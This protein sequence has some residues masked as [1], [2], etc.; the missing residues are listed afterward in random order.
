MNGKITR[1]LKDKRCGFIKGEDRKDY[2]FHQ[3]GLKNCQFLDLEEG[4]KV[5]FE[6]TESPKGP[7]AEEIFV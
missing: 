6:E 4:Q 5:E 1:L 2:F 3:S 7:R